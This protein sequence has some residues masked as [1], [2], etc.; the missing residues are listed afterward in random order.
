[1]PDINAWKRQILE[2]SLNKLRQDF[3][4]AIN[5]RDRALAAPDQNR[6]QRQADEIWEQIEKQNSEL[7]SLELTLVNNSVA[8]SKPNSASIQKKL[9]SQLH[10]ID[11]K[12][13]SKTIDIVL[14]DHCDGGC[15][16]LLLFQESDTRGGEWCAALIREL[17]KRVTNEGKFREIP[18]RFEARE[19]AN[20]MELL[21]RIGQYLGIE[22]KSHDSTNSLS[23]NV[24]QTLR[25]SLQNGSVVMIHCQGCDDIF[26]EIDEFYRILEDFWRNMVSELEMV[27]KQ[28][29]EV[30]IITLL[31]T[32]SKPLP[33][34]NP[35]DYCCTI[36]QFQKNKLLKLPQEEWTQED[37]R[38]WIARY[39]V[40]DDLDPSQIDRMAK[41]IYE[42]AGGIPHVIGDKL[43][44]EC[45]PM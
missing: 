41:R 10:N 43:L 1:M 22:A 38:V 4:A 14:R 5:Q 28:C 13:L 33:D 12:E 29:Y 42:S 2:N 27:S 17:L 18:V 39:S 24:I 15:A 20:S 26:D 11:F 23:Q 19:K 45:C 16:A 40:R 3:E 7:E 36:E 8:I 21:R 25:R 6:L 44:Q 32:G 35:V 31:F 30:K 37:I 9:E 34:N